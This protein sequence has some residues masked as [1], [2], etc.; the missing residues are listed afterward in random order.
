V[1]VFPIRLPPLRARRDDIPALTNHFAERAGLRLFGVPLI[2][3]MDDIRQLQAYD[4]PGNVRELAAVIERAAILGDGHR[5][6]VRSAL[7]V[8]PLAQ[9]TGSDEPTPGALETANRKAISEA[10]ERARGKIEGPHGAA[11]LLGI[12][13]HTLRARMRKL[14]IDWSQYRGL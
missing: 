9:V 10:L 11:A 12:N 8:A 7:G 2:P 6:E 3:Q 13:P 1:S 5:L 4:W 14:G